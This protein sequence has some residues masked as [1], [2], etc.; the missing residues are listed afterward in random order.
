MTTMIRLNPSRLSTNLLALALAVTASAADNN[1]VTVAPVGA[2]AD[3]LNGGIVYALPATVVR[4]TITARVIVETVGPYYKYSARYLNVND[5]VQAD[6]QRWQIMG[7]RVATVGQA[8]QQRRFKVSA[9]SHDAMPAVALRSD[10]RLAGINL[11]KAAQEQE[12][13][14]VNPTLPT[15]NM[16]SVP[17]SQDILSRTS[18]AAMAEGVAQAIYDMRAQ[19]RALIAGDHEAQLPGAGALATALRELARLER[20]HMEL[21]IGHRDTL[22]VVRHFDIVPDYNGAGNLVPVRFSDTHGFLDALDLT[23]KPVYVDMEFDDKQRLNTMPAAARKTPLSGLK[24]IQPGNLTVKVTDRNIPLCQTRVLCTQNGQIADL[25]AALLTTHR[26]T[27]D[28]AT[29]AISD[30]RPID[31]AAATSKK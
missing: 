19:R 26:V 14:D 13:A 27:I 12:T 3:A 16:E 7:A 24:Y 20:L 17:L 2:D 21:F 9:A 1:A 8:D 29:G 30:L 6:G 18:S 25:P 22:T 4:V 10:G 11:R 15:F 23:G 5:P 31:K 28:P